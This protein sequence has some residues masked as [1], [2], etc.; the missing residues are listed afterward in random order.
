MNPNR[1]GEQAAPQFEAGPSMGP[2]Q[3]D[4]NVDTQVEKV[5][6][7]ESSP[8]SQ[9]APTMPVVQPLALPADDVAV[10]VPDDFQPS[11]A[12]TNDATAADVDRIEKQWIDRAKAI[13]AQTKDDPYAQ[14]REMSKVKAA[15]IEKRFNKKLKVDDAV[16]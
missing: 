11:Q 7:P 6:T 3:I 16:A 15:Y 9:L 13:V 2:E 14:N 1:V 5:Q 10:A 12:Q 8:S 4:D